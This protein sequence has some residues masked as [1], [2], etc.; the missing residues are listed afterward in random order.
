M[1]YKYQN[2]IRKYRLPKVNRTP[3]TIFL[4]VVPERAAPDAEFTHQ[5]NKSFVNATGH[6]YLDQINT[7]HFLYFDDII[8]SI[9]TK[10][11]V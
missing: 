4:N 8:D 11:R 6:V 10:P 3:V 5:I 9:I 7:L 2:L 1:F